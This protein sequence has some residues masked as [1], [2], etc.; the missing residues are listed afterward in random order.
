MRAVVGALDG[1]ADA[2]RRE[3]LVGA[4]FEQS[5][6]SLARAVTIVAGMGENLDQG[7]VHLTVIPDALARR[8]SRQAVGILPTYRVLT[9]E[10]CAPPG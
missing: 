6:R 5:L 10:L 4:G 9:P 2:P 8:L 1:D 7:N 3:S